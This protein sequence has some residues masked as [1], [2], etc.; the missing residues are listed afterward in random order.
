MGKD[1]PPSGG[2]NGVGW[3]YVVIR[4]K[5]GNK[6]NLPTLWPGEPGMCLD[7]GE[8]YVG[9]NHGNQ[10]IG[11]PWITPEAYGAKGDGVTDDTVAIQAAVDGLPST[12]GTVMFSAKLYAIGTTVHI[13]KVN[14]SL[15]GQAVGSRISGGGT[16][17]LWIG[18]D[19]GAT[20]GMIYAMGGG[21]L[22]VSAHNFHIEHIALE[23]DS[24]ANV[25]L[26]CE[27]L[28]TS[29]Y[30]KSPSGEHLE[31][32]G[33]KTRGLVIG[34]DD[35][36]NSTA[37]GQGIAS[38]RNLR[39][40]PT[41]AASISIVVN[42]QNFEMTTLTDVYIDGVVH[43]NAIYHVA[44]GLF[45]KNL[46]TTRTDPAN[47]AV[48]SNNSCTIDGWRSEDK[49]LFYGGATWRSGP[50]SLRN[51]NNRQGYDG[52]VAYTLATEYPIKFLGNG[53][54]F[55]LDNVYTRGSIYV[56]G[57]VPVTATGITFDTNIRNG[58]YVWTAS[59][60]GTN[61][62]YLSVIGGGSS[63]LAL[64]PVYI[65]SN[66]VRLVKGT[67]GSLA[68]DTWGWGDNDTL[69]YN[70][71]YIRLADGTDPDTKAVD[72]IQAYG[73]AQLATVNYSQGILFNDTDRGSLLLQGG[74]RTLVSRSPILGRLV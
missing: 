62:Y 47:Y 71:V 34:A 23:G 36:V 11:G 42:A 9:A 2:N 53:S 44:G 3:G 46:V 67:L 59:G 20:D 73:A 1:I 24:K 63:G 10:R 8:L 21:G 50:T 40:A 22:V 25:C 49:L 70:T 52:D 29:S 74:N 54:P 61:E 27:S 6:I 30:C 19:G 26:K 16:R 31:F 69:G 68:V 48:V 18:A 66:E 58:R 33:Y 35:I 12:G 14:V 5:R 37:G 32:R 56:S 57:F 17:I 13:D 55:T 43:A 39:F 41:V 51:V 4:V 64:E 7:T 65:R 38:F 45:I 60:S 15:V 72:Y 28:P